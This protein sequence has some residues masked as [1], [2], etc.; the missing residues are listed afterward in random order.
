MDGELNRNLN[1]DASPF[2]SL[3]VAAKCIFL[4]I[5][6]E[7]AGFDGHWNLRFIIPIALIF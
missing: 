2:N 1:V 5:F 4:S 6:I 7:V 3:S